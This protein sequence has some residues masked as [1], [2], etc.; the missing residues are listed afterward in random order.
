MPI[1]PIQLL[2][3]LDP[4]RRTSSGR[5]PVGPRPVF[6]ERTFD[7]LLLLA[8]S[9]RVTSDR[10]VDLGYEPDEAFTD[11]QLARLAAAADAASSAGATTAL[12]LIDGRGV[13]LDV[14][15]RRLDSE[16]SGRATDEVVALDA[17]VYVRGP[18]DEGPETALPPPGGGVTPRGVASQFLSDSSSSS[19]SAA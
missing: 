9:G 2:N 1:D 10:P 11:E 19:S 3:R 15:G 12:L 6:E 4:A 14:A 8:T 18:D 13:V 7:D 16:L 5:A 17:A